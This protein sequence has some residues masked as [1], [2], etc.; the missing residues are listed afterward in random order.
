MTRQTLS[1][2]SLTLTVNT[3]ALWPIMCNLSVQFY[4]HGLFG[5][6]ELG[7]RR[8]LKLFGYSR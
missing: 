3:L 2:G 5:L 7:S 1:F 8:S 4:L 6:E